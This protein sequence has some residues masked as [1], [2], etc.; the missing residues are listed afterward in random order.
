MRL[1]SNAI[2]NSKRSTGL[3]KL[4]AVD[5]NDRQIVDNNVFPAVT[6]LEL[7]RTYFSLYKTSHLS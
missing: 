6:I 1:F 7:M 5:D 2:D 4:R 3:R